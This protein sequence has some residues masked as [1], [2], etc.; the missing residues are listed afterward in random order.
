MNISVIYFSVLKKITGKS[1]ETIH[2]EKSG[3]A[4]DLFGILAQE[5]P[6]MEKYKTYMRLSVNQQYLPFT[7]ELKPNDEVVFI[8]PVSG[9]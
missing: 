7:T 2:M 1:Q 4:E 5:Y 8:T 3:N 6:E 9:G